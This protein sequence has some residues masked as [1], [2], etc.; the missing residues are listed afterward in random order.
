MNF[1]DIPPFTRSASYAVDIS[2]EHLPRSYARYVVE[3]GLNVNPDFQRK[4]VW[5]NDQKSRFIEYVL[6]GGTS[7]RDIYT[8]DPTWKVGDMDKRDF[9]LVDGK[10]RLDAALGFLNNEVK[11]FGLY[12]REFTG[13]MRFFHGFRW[14]V[15]D[16]QTREE[17]LGWYIDLNSGGT[18]HT[19]DEIEHVKVLLANKTPAPV[20]PDT[21]RL[22]EARID[23]EVLAQPLEEIQAELDRFAYI[24]ANPQ[25]PPV[26]AKKKGRRTR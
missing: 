12:F 22:A 2:F 17:I 13:H 7:G 10:Q 16:L 8:N 19:P 11:A 26:A 1:K 20:V 6:R 18:P 3:H 9:V 23:R 25:P 5:T 14:H 21:Q 24:A 4:Y 15:N